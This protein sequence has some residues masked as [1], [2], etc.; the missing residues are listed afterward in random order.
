MRIEA[1]LRAERA[2]STAFTTPIP[3]VP[4]PLIGTVTGKRTQFNAARVAV[5]AVKDSA[6]TT[7]AGLWA[8]W[9]PTFA[10]RPAIDLAVEDSTEEEERLRLALRDMEQQAKGMLVEVEKRIKKGDD[11]LVEA[12]SAGGEK[13]AGLQI[14][15]AKSFLGD[16]LRIVPRFT[17]SA[18][19][20]DE[21]QNGFDGRA[22]LVAHLA[23]GHDFPV[24]EWMHGL[25]RVRPKM[26]AFENLVLATGALGTTEPVLMPVQF[27]FR[28]AEPWLAMELPPA[29]ELSAAGDH[30]LYTAAYPNGAFD[31]NAAAF[32]GLLLDEWTEVLPAKA[33]TAALAF[34]YDRPSHEPPQTMLLVTPATPGDRWTWED[35]RAAIPETFELAKKRAVE[36][37]DIAKKPVARFLPATLMAFTTHAVSISSELRPAEVAFA[38]MAVH[39]G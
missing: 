13:K 36:P 21:W 2:I 27:P 10:G 32:G 17:L 37:R 30:V 3:N 31:K 9:Q 24:D 12:A 25:A 1:L 6:A 7:I 11:L 19:Q 28:A 34:H 14:D 39:D 23:A 4:G 16:G 29:F 38:S 8:Q 33:E 18:L 26:H 5:Q 35:L 15:A 20:A 22:N